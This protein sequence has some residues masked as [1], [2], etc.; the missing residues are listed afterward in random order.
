[1]KPISRLILIN[2]LIMAMVLFLGSC[3]SKHPSPVESSEQQENIDWSKF[4]A[5]PEVKELVAVA[6]FENKSTYSADKLWD[7]SSQILSSSLIRTNYFRVVEWEK[8]KQLFDWDTLS[9]ASLVKSPENLQRAQ[10][11]LLCEYFISGS[12]T[13]FDVS[14]H[15]SVSAM[16]KSK[17][18]DTTV[19][20]DLLLQDARTGEYLSTGSGEQTIQQAYEG[21]LSGGQTGGWSSLSADKALTASINKALLELVTNFARIKKPQG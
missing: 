17:V 3:L 2:G 16:S 10:R 21:G 5:P 13:Y 9:H 4:P 7:T 19:R 1:L 12:I 18:I 8:M 11:I 6:G 20:V 15:A 14:Q